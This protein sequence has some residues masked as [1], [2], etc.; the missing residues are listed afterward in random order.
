VFAKVRYFFCQILLFPT[1]DLTCSISAKILLA[2]PVSCHLRPLLPNL[3]AIAVFLH[4]LE[5]IQKK[6]WTDATPHLTS[7]AYINMISSRS[8]GK[9]DLTLYVNASKTSFRIFR[10]PI[11]RCFYNSQVINLKL[12]EIHTIENVAFYPQRCPDHY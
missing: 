10:K 3:R 6:Y 8:L 12:F 2:K 7:Y 4:F 5:G 9:L 1:D 11:K